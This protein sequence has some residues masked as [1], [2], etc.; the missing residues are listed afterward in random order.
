V[1]SER[2]DRDAADIFAVQ[3][4]IAAGV[5]EAVQAKLMA[6]APAVRTRPQVGNLEAYREYLKGRH[7]RYMKA[8]YV[9]ALGC[10]ERAVDLDPS[11]AA[12]WIGLADVNLVASF[13]CL[14][15]AADAFAAAKKALATAGRLQGESAEALL[16]ESMIAVGERAW[17]TAERAVLRA[18]ELQPAFVPA[19][20]W[21]AWRLNAF[22]RLDEA[23]P[24]LQ[25]AREVDP[26]APYPYAMTGFTLLAGGRAVEAVR[27]FDQALTFESENILAQ[28][29]AGLAQVA[30]GRPADGVAL[31]ERATTHSRRGG[32]IHGALGWALANAGRTDDARR[33]VDELKARPAPAPAAVSQ[34][35]LLAALDR[36]DAA[37]DVL[38]RAEREQQISLV[39]IGLPGYDPL[40]A[41]PRFRAL[42]ERLGLPQ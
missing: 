34:A 10:F 12:S 42:V 5:V 9:A 41:D 29:G 19:R 17:R 26:L 33:V 18:I 27:Y 7:L 15:P 11:N 23:L 39:L 35:W 25:Y 16:A 2:F 28:C 40:R 1:W 21:N 24:H 22:G 6:G 20:C 38:E 36:P 14:I 32:F 37:I 8:D 4:E 3:D 13:Y 30:V 31:L